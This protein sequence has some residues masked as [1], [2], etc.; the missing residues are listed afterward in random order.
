MSQPKQPTNEDCADMFRVMMWEMMEMHP[1]YQDLRWQV[2]NLSGVVAAKG[3]RKEIA[4]L[5]R[6]LAETFRSFD[7]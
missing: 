5:V 7:E 6:K 1:H 4:H 2:K 3:S